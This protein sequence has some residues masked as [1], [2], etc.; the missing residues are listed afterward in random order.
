[1]VTLTGK[2]FDGWTLG[3]RLASTLQ[4]ESYEGM[5]GA[6]ELSVVRVLPQHLA[7]SQPFRNRF[8]RECRQAATIVSPNVVRYLGC[9]V[10]HNRPWFATERLG[11]GD[12]L[13]R[14]IADGWHPTSEQ[15]MSIAVQAW[16]GLA[17]A[18]L[19]GMTHRA[20]HP[21]EM[22]LDEA[23]VLR[24]C[25][26]GMAP[27]P[28][29]EEAV[30]ATCNTQQPAECL[31]PE[32]IRNA[33]Y[34]VRGD[35]YAMACALYWV[36]CGRPPFVAETQAGIIEQQ[37]Q[38]EAP[39][40]RRFAADAPAELSVLF[41]GLLA[42]DPAARQPQSVLEV[43]QICEAMRQGGQSTRRLLRTAQTS[44]IR[45]ATSKPP[46][47]AA[48]PSP[49]PNPPRRPG[50]SK[51]VSPV[52][53]LLVLVLL[54]VIWVLVTQ[55]GASVAPAGAQHPEA[56]AQDLE[57]RVQ[58]SAAAEVP[59]QIV[60]TAAGTPEPIVERVAE[61][62]MPKLVMPPLAD[63]AVVKALVERSGHLGPVA[64]LRMAL[65]EPDVTED[66]GQQLW[67]ADYLFIV[68]KG[69]VISAHLRPGKKP[70]R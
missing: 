20:L 30:L 37:L 55:P 2:Q 36:G 32:Q 44:T 28:S 23:G 63:P 4:Y 54:G 8:L 39:P 19:A 70:L 5:R 68:E 10:G 49:E 59:V 57:K 69:F 3:A 58:Q 18:T 35:L 53:A 22:H 17:A 61:P 47:A 29:G 9:G 34:D 64:D 25:G 33:P 27:D 38:A 41:N 62:P 24:L 6:G 12:Y 50:R 21:A 11:T 56:G 26:F 51:L 16:R 66:G 40:L 15:L 43:L 45:A 42:K 67:F 7:D 46:P 13:S 14:R 48:P 60:P 31:A 1:M 65:G 52:L